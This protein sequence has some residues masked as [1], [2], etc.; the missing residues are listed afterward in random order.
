M[1]VDV[2]MRE[3]LDQGY[4]IVR[5]C[6]PPDQLESMRQHCELMLERHKQWWVDEPYL[7][8]GFQSK[9][10]TTYNFNAMPAM[11]VE[12]FIASW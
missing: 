2:D 3:M 10:P 1:T 9:E 12:E 8:P 5:Q 6:V 4:L 11:N 7:L